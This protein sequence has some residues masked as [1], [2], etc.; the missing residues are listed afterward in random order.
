MIF[1][2]KNFIT[3]RD[4]F[5]LFSDGNKIK[6]MNGDVFRELNSLAA[7]YLKGNVCID[8]NFKNETAVSELPDILS[9]NCGFCEK[10]T[11]LTNCEIQRNFERMEKRIVDFFKTNETCQIQL[12]TLEGKLNSCTETIKYQEKLEA[13]RQE[14]FDALLNS[15]KDLVDVKNQEIHNLQNEIKALKSEIINIQED[16]KELKLKLESVK[17]H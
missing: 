12:V 11:A 15:H 16:N 6:F 13:Q 9:E 4:I 2:F 5:I 10:L 3:C 17:N 8:A 1:Y 14:S 7:V